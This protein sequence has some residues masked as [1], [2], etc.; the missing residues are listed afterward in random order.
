MLK[1]ESELLE[2]RVE[3]VNFNVALSVVR[4][5]EALDCFEMAKSLSSKEY[6]F[7]SELKFEK[8]RINYL[9]GRL[10]AKGAA[11]AL[12]GPIPHREII[13]EQGV[14]PFPVVRGEK[15]SGTHV[16][17]AHT[18]QLAVAIAHDQAFPCGIDIEQLIRGQEDPL[19]TL[20]TDSEKRIGL[21]LNIELSKKLTLFWTAKESL[22]KILKTG[23]T[24]PLIL[25]EIERIKKNQETYQC[26][27][28]NFLQ[29]KTLSFISDNHALSIALPKHSEGKL[30]KSTCVKL[31]LS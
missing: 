9:M 14:F 15:V 16:S 17:I 21:E 18:G 23:F 20:L 5:D 19:S 12:C 22:S 1:H 7:F 29:Y 28:R 2:F 8:K 4:F 11:S 25:F 13:I 3:G 26:T 6:R 27:F 31:A 30:E 10:A 24:T